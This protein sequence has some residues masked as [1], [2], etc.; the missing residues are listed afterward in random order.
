[1]F[2]RS[3]LP[4]GLLFSG[5]LIMSNKAYLYLSVHYIQM[6]KAFNPVAILFISWA[7]RLKEPNKR[8][9]MIV[10]AISSGVALASKGELRFDLYGFII[11]AIAVAVSL[12]PGL[13]K[14]VK[15]NVNFVL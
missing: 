1:M 2:M 11:Q 9:A 12:V 4:I 7:T 8:I 6:L 5:S 13:S 3:I 14:D 15:P 10:L